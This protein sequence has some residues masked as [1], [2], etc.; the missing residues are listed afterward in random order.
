MWAH[1]DGAF[2]IL[3]W[4]SEASE[5]FLGWLHATAAASTAVSAAGVLNLVLSGAGKQ[6]IGGHRDKYHTFLYSGS[7]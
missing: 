6:F 4:R 2:E 7:N 1:E 3:E 5:V